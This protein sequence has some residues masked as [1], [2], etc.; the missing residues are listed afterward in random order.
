MCAATSAT[1][2]GAARV[3]PS[4]EPMMPVPGRIATCPSMASDSASLSPPRL[5]SDTR[6]TTC[7]R[8]DLTGDYFDGRFEGNS[9]LAL[10]CAGE[11]GGYQFAPST[12]N[13][14]VQSLRS[15]GQWPMSDLGTLA[16]LTPYLGAGLGATNLRFSDLSQNS[17]CVAGLGRLLRGIIGNSILWWL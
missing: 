5:V 1:R 7:F 8:A 12:R 14:D 4:T 10:P 15:D 16:G 11:G 2:P 9:T 13:A 6:S 17:S 3:I